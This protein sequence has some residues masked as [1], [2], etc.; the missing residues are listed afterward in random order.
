MSERASVF[1][2]GSDFDVAGFAPQKPKVSAPAE[3]VREVSESA[4]FKSREP[5]EQKKPKREPRRYRTGRNTQ[6]NIKADPDVIED[7]YG[8]ADAQGWVLGETLE[9][10]VKALKNE[11]AARAGQG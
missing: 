5:S 2:A 10:A 11:I 1:D 6:L 8:V 3:K 4:S 9:R 7:F